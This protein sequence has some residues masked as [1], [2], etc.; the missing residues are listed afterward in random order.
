MVANM[1]ALFE[2]FIETGKIA[3]RE[4]FNSEGDGFWGFK[5]Y[6]L[7]AYGWYSSRL[8]RAFVISHFVV[9]K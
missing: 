3:N 5:A 9:K 7:R 6:Q 8:P 4:R 1:E 2:T